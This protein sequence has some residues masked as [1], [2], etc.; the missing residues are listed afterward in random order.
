[1]IN[2]ENSENKIMK[3]HNTKNKNKEKHTSSKTKNK[4]KTKKNDTDNQ[5]MLMQELE[6]LVDEA[7]SKYDT[8]DTTT[9]TTTTTTATTTTTNNNNNNINDKN[10]NNTINNNDKDKDIN[11]KKLEAM[12]D[13]AISK[14]DDTIDVSKNKSVNTECYTSDMK[15]LAVKAVKTEKKRRKDRKEKENNNNNKNNKNDM[16]NSSPIDNGNSEVNDEDNIIDNTM[17]NNDISKEENGSGMKNTIAANIITTTTATTAG[18]TTITTDVN[19]DNH[20]NNSNVSGVKFINNDGKEDDDKVTF[21]TNN[22]ANTTTTPTPTVFSATNDDN[23]TN[24]DGLNETTPMYSSDLI[25]NETTASSKTSV[26]SATN[27]NTN[28]KRKAVVNIDDKSCKRRRLPKSN[29]KHLSDVFASTFKLQSESSVPYFIS[30]GIIK[31]SFTSTDKIFHKKREMK[32]DTTVARQAIEDIYKKSIDLL[33]EYIKKNYISSEDVDDDDD[34]DDDIDDEQEKDE[35]T[36][37]S[38]SLSKGLY[39]TQICKI[40]S[41]FIVKGFE[42]KLKRPNKI[43]RFLLSISKKMNQDVNKCQSTTKKSKTTAVLPGSSIQKLQMDIANMLY[44]YIL[45]VFPRGFMIIY[46]KHIE[47]FVTDNNITDALSSRR[48]HISMDEYSVDSAVDLILLNIVYPKKKELYR[49]P[50]DDPIYDFISEERKIFAFESVKTKTSVQ[51]PVS[52]SLLC[53]NAHRYLT[54]LD[55]MRMELNMS[56]DELMETV[57][58]PVSID[59]EET[60]ARYSSNDSGHNNCEATTEIGLIIKCYSR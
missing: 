36:I 25:A 41:R 3:P 47:K 57:F 44:H 46:K 5:K 11:E 8:T 19:N 12:V 1:M 54:H 14:F 38:Y 35:Q 24:R 2:K 30:S 10:N 15:P 23:D 21:I 52:K 55:K 4:N 6:V 56:P 17:K 42:G 7:I 59:M 32:Y 31:E 33:T 37:P 22:I 29:L 48:D 9:T 34:D 45:E 50:E 53:N 39:N 40:I 16:N 51:R 18:A 58:L 26:Y 49:F 43:K 13:E 28:G 60:N 20:Y 27:K